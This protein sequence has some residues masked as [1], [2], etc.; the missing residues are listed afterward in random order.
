VDLNTS[1]TDNAGVFTSFKRI[2]VSIDH[3][4]MDSPV[5]FTSI[6]AGID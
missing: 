2:I 4:A 3:S 6:V 5:V 1:W